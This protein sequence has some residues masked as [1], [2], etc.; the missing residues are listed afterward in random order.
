MPR[1]LGAALSGTVGSEVRLRLRTNG[2][3]PRV[4]A[5]VERYTDLDRELPVAISRGETGVEKEA[6]PV[7]QAVNGRERYGG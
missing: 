1:R 7:W 3:S 4:T 2:P 5:T 6:K